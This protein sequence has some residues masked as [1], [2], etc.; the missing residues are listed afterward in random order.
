[1]AVILLNSEVIPGD[2]ILGQQQPPTL[3]KAVMAVPTGTVNQWYQWTDGSIP[4]ATADVQ[5]YVNA[6][7]L[8]YRQ[9]ALA[10]GAPIMNQTQME[11]QV[12]LWRHWTYRAVFDE[13]DFR[14][15]N[16]MY[17]AAVPPTIITVAAY[18]TV[19]DD[20]ETYLNTQLG[21]T[22]FDRSYKNDR[23]AIPGVGTTAATAFTTLAQCVN[24]HSILRS[25]IADR[26]ATVERIQSTGV[27]NQ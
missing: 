19:I 27:L 13:A 25:W 11:L 10:A 1:M 8:Q 18:R 3:I 21:T 16:G 23:F 5:A 7:E 9:E 6:N 15:R 2:I 20:V 12:D 4:I 17:N 26:I 14:L 24:C 22:I